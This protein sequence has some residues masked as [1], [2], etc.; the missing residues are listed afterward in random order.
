MCPRR[1]F[2]KGPIT[3]VAAGKKERV[4]FHK[5][6]ICIKQLNLRYDAHNTTG[7]S[8]NVWIIKI[9]GTE[10]LNMPFEDIYQYLAAYMVT[11]QSN[12]P[13]ICV[14]YSGDSKTYTVTFHDL[15]RVEESIEIW[16][17]N[18]DSSNDCNVWVSMV[19]DI[20]E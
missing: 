6:E 7:S 5:G 2:Y 9:D 12:R 16:M 1:R 10:I 18:V 3:S 19:Y 20:L 14:K 4:L 17:K 13:V 11:S 8:K 15:G